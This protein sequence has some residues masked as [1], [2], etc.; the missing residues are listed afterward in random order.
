VESAGRSDSLANYSFGIFR[1]RKHGDAC[2]NTHDPVDR[3]LETAYTN[4]F[5]IGLMRAT[6]LMLMMYR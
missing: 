1:C 3:V 2:D 6:E 4:E 5:G